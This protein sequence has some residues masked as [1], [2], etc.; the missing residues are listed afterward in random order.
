MS[1]DSFPEL[2]L[3]VTFPALKLSGQI[4]SAYLR[5]LNKRP[6]NSDFSTVFPV[7][8]DKFTEN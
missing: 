4:R 5:N 7:V 8:A 3:P 2:Q 6:S 1:R